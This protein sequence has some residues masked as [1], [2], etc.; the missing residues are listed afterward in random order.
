[1]LLLWLLPLASPATPPDTPSV[2]PAR[3][4]AEA[5][6]VYQRYGQPET[7]WGRGRQGLYTMLPA[8]LRLGHRFGVGSVLELGLQ[9]RSRRA[10]RTLQRSYDAAPAYH[11]WQR[12]RDVSSLA[13]S[14]TVSSPVAR[15]RLAATPWRLDARVGLAFVRARFGFWEYRTYG[16]SPVPFESTAG[17]YRRVLADLPLLAG[18]RVGYA[19][20][21]HLELTAE[22]NGSY[23]PLLLLAVGFGSAAS[24][25]G[26]GAGLGLR[27]NF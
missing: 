7:V 19:L 4:Y 26:G 1:M 8:Q 6:A 23:S 5:G 21:R 12:T 14:V 11:Y 13:V 18:V 20:S 3:W 10:P 15:R 16:S 22:A 27:Y 25:F 17:E 24:P 9:Y 2:A